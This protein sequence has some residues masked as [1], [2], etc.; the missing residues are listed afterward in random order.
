[1]LRKR[2]IVGS[3]LILSLVLVLWLDGVIDRLAMPTWVGGL[4]GRETFPPGT[5]LFPLAAGLSLIAARELAAMLRRK[6]IAASARASTT[7]ALVGLVVATFVPE[8]L[9]AVDAAAVVAT[10]A[11]GVLV[12]SIVF[13]ARHCTVEGVIAAT[14]STL[15]AFV[16]LGLL[17]G[18]L[19]AIRRQHEVWI[20]LWVLL[21]T[22]SCDIGAY[23]T[24][25]AIGRHKLIPW[26]SPGK[27]WEGL[28]GGIVFASLIGA[29]GALLLGRSGVEG[30]PTPG[31]G[32]AAGVL[33]SLV[34]H[35]GD[36]MASVLKRDTG[37]KDTG[38]ALPGMGGLIDVL[39]SPL[40]VFPA[41]YWLLALS[42]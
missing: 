33:F 31:V 30:S 7:A 38:S 28:F 39:D 12:A 37:V 1:M 26:L 29:V 5:L 11:V 24:G 4:L 35:A 2:V 32:A 19:L 42:G 22:K 6:G 16:Y 3:L 9:S 15:F 40:L 27:T 8:A 18:F 13:H 21:V 20:I 17:F 36:L 23:F 34:G 41:A 10:A 14:G 25:S